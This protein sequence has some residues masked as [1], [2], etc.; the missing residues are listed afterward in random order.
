M[1]RCVA[2]PER[3]SVVLPCFFCIMQRTRSRGGIS[4]S[5]SY[6]C[7]SRERKSKLQNDQLGAVHATSFCRVSHAEYNIVAGRPYRP[8]SAIPYYALPGNMPQ[9][10]SL[11][12]RQY[13]HISRRCPKL[14]F[15]SNL[16][17][18]ICT[19]RTFFS[20]TDQHIGHAVSPYSLA[21]PAVLIS[22]MLASPKLVRTQ[23][24][25]ERHA[26]CA[27]QFCNSASPAVV[28]RMPWGRVHS[29]FKK[30]GEMRVAGRRCREVRDEDP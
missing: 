25:Q 12:H 6:V 8:N 13:S 30:R 27:R 14:S 23:A 18:S 28:L 11:P 7:S 26:I 10:P 17:G 20:C 29:T 15:A 3:A 5:L 4:L 22:C 19:G 1:L 2:L 16:A 9:N 21:G 24:V